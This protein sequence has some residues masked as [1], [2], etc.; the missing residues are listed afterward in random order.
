MTDK[1]DVDLNTCFEKVSAFKSGHITE[2]EL[3]E[4]EHQACQG[5]VRVLGCC[6]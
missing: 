5:V 4:V 6:C 2:E 1:Q 3:D